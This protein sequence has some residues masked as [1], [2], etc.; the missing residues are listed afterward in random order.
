MRRG[1]C[2]GGPIDGKLMS[3]NHG[4][5]M[6]HAPTGSRYGWNEGQWVYMGPQDSM[7]ASNPAANAAAPMVPD[8]RTFKFGGQ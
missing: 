3:V 7:V 8:V 2:V 1:Y 6:I 5:S 4:S